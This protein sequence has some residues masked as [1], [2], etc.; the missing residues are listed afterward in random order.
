MQRGNTS[1]HYASYDGH[2]EL[3]ELLLWAKADV[4]AKDEVLEATRGDRS[5]GTMRTEP[6][7]RCHS[8]AYLW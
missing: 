8:R 7:Q 2:T 1:L 3:C 6:G 5:F 4:E